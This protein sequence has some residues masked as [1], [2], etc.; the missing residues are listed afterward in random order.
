MSELVFQGETVDDLQNGY[1]I[2]QEGR[3]FQI[4][5]R[6]GIVVRILLM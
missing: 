2:I 5:G 6:C 4:W 3:F 1:S